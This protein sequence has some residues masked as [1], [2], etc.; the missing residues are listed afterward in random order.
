MSCSSRSRP[1]VDKAR[2]ILREETADG[3]A[4]AAHVKAR[5]EAQDISDSTAKRARKRE[6][7]QV[8]HTHDGHH[9]NAALYTATHYAPPDH[10]DRI[11][12]IGLEGQ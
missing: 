1:E 4:D 11:G 6:N 7:I 5:M 12:P 10:I 9:F 8:T 3:P 2:R